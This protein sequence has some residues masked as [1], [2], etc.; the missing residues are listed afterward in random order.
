MGLKGN[1]TCAFVTRGKH[2]DTFKKKVYVLTESEIE[3]M[4]LQAKEYQ[5][6]RVK[7][8]RNKE[9]SFLK[10]LEDVWFC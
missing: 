10:F 1:M 2:I 3:A 4:Q 9:E 7:L 6:L 5:G 8:G